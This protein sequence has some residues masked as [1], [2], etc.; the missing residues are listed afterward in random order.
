[1]LFSL[2]P[3]ALGVVGKWES[4]FLDFHFSTTHNWILRFSR[5]IKISWFFRLCNGE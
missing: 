5:V 2:L 1:M 3:Q 4:W